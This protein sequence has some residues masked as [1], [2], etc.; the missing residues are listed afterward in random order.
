[1]L[2]DEYG[3]KGSFSRKEGLEDVVMELWMEM[4]GYFFFEKF[5]WRYGGGKREVGL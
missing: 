3:N 1:M 2:K 4:N 5:S